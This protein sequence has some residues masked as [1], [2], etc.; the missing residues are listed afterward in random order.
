MKKFAI[1]VLIIT[2]VL[3][4]VAVAWAMLASDSSSV[5]EKMF[6]GVTL[7]IAGNTIEI[8]TSSIGQEAGMDLAIGD[9]ATLRVDNFL[10]SPDTYVDPA[11]EGYYSLGY[12]VGEPGAV[13]PQPFLVMYI[14]PTQFFIIELL[15]EPL[16]EVRSLAEQ[17]TARRLGI[18]PSDLCRLNYTIGTSARVNTTYAGR[19]LG[20][21]F[22]P[23]ATVLPE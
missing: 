8:P 20:F 13:S 23:G 6:P 17:Y 19:N 9:G 16:G 15:Q 1:I 7:P 2:A 14:A 3:I 21:S 22:C 10:A 12:S 11:N 5:P 4:V 18:S